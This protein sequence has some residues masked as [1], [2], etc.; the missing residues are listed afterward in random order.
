MS[1]QSIVAL[2]LGCPA[3]PS[4]PAQR[5]AWVSGGFA[6]RF[7]IA[8][9]WYDPFGLLHTRYYGFLSPKARG[10]IQ[11]ALRFRCFNRFNDLR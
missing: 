6:G 1:L 4:K 8:M 7:L 2:D 9:V 5:V 3:K 10:I 11:P